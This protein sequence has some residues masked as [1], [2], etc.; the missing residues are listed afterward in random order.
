M[1]QFTCNSCQDTHKK[2]LECIEIL[3]EACEYALDGLI[4]TSEDGIRKNS[5]VQVRAALKHVEKTMQ[6]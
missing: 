2:N 5:I 1:I 6:K 4:F 3:K